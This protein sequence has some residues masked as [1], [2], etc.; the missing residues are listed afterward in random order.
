MVTLY[1]SFWAP[2]RGEIGA[3]KAPAGFADHPCARLDGDRLGKRVHPQ[4]CR[5]QQAPVAALRS[6]AVAAEQVE[7]LAVLCAQARLAGGA[8]AQHGG[9]A[10]VEKHGHSSRS[11]RAAESRTAGAGKARQ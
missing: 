11:A 2:M 3:A 5:R 9:K 4:P 6:H 1:P 10:V 7:Q 8:L